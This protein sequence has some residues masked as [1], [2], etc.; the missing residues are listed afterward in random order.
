MPRKPFPAVTP[1]SDATNVVQEQEGQEAWSFLLDAEA[2]I[3]TLPGPQSRVPLIAI[4]VPT[5]KQE[6]YDKLIQALFRDGHKCKI[7]G[8]YDRQSIKLDKIRERF[9]ASED[10]IAVDMEVAHIFSESAQDGSKPNF[11]DTCGDDL[12]IFQD[13]IPDRIQFS[14]DPVAAAAALAKGKVLLLPDPTLLAL[15]AACARVANLSGAAEQ[16]D[17]ILRDL[18]E[19]MVLA[20]DRSMADLLSTRLTM[21][22]PTIPVHW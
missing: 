1:L 20:D 4:R 16:A 17:S 18:E 10:R 15:R 2:Y 5:T 14:V 8:C 3:L 13:P 19:T 12:D 11:Y 6:S 9:R 21:L 7:S 22:T